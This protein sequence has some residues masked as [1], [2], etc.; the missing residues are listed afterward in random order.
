MKGTGEKEEM[1]ERDQEKDLD[2][3][4][5]LHAEIQKIIVN[6]EEQNRKMIL[7][8]IGELKQKTREFW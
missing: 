1:T 8:L 3:R 4:E 6:I 2:G 5:T 7:R